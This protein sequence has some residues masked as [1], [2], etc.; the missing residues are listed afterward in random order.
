MNAIKRQILN[1][2][3]IIY[4]LI[5]L[6]MLSTISIIAPITTEFNVLILL[7]GALYFVYDFFKEKTYYKSRYSKILIV[8]MIMFFIGILINYKNNLIGNI[9]TFAY[10][11]FFL[12][13]VYSYKNDFE[14]RYT[15]KELYN[16]N[17][18]I[19]I[20]SSIVSFASLLTF[21]FFIQFTYNNVPQGFVYPN[22]PALWGF[23]GNP[24]S[25]GMVAVISIIATTFNI[26]LYKSLKDKNSSL[27][28]K[29]YYYLNIIVQ[30]LYLILCNSRGAV[31]SLLAFII[32]ASFYLL[33][34]F[35]K[36]DKK[37][38]NIKSIIIS[39]LLTCIISFVYTT[40]IPSLK[41]GLAHIPKTID[42][43]INSEKSNVGVIETESNDEVIELDRNIESGHVSTGRV[44]IWTYG[45][46]TLKLNPLF[47]HGPDNIG[48]AKQKI[49]PN[50][51]SRYMVTNNMHNGYLQILLS[52]GIL[53][54]IAFSLFIILIVKDT[55]FSL[56]STKIISD[57][58]SYIPLFF[59]TGLVL[60]IAVNG[61]FENVILL[62]QSYITTVLWIYL[63]YLSRRLDKAK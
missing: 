57:K 25:G 49:Y 7:W 18:I 46:N 29:I 11:G 23:Y 10:T 24:N 32:F 36:E 41:K 60:S 42:K 28:R 20:I 26:Y 3:N 38:A 13:V 21:I 62:T 39:L 48:L 58:S 53:G 33:F 43:L 27:A 52:N 51:K 14:E 9:K 6:M 59:I 5:T 45:L 30:F 2:N 55:L 61:L 63:S 40:S 16:I 35:F 50:D 17:S 1:K 4:S 54:F 31:I 22:S 44:E 34:I 56:F 12:F 15:Q 8:Y 37:M 19:I 47:G